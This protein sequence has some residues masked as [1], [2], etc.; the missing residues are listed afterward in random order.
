M[1]M[2]GERE[3]GPEGI[4]SATNSSSVVVEVPESSELDVSGIGDWLSEAG[5]TGRQ[6]ESQERRRSMKPQ[7]A[8]RRT[9]GGNSGSPVFATKPCH[10]GRCLQNPGQHGLV[11]RLV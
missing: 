7:T 10:S 1:R 5:I 2:E 8:P 6:L 9:D 4:V 3:D 11:K